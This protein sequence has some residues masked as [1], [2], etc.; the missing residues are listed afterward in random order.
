VKTTTRVLDFLVGAGIAVEVTRR[1]KRRLF[2]LKGMAS[3]A[4]AVRPPYRAEPRR[5]RGRPPVVA[6]DDVV[7]AGAS[8]PLPP[9]AP[10]ERRAFDYSDLERGMTQ[11]DLVLRQT[12]RSLDAL[13]RGAPVGA[14][15]APAGG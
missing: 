13:A 1:S 3:L 9:L 14:G 7:I 15:S 11:L 6:A 12:R 4:D 10:I 2:G 5:G 8:V